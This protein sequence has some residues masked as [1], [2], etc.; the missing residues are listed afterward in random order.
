[1]LFFS[2]IRNHPLIGLANIAR[3]KQPCKAKNYPFIFLPARLLVDGKPVAGAMRDFGV[4]R[5]WG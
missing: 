4:L 2:V 1:V 3:A 5:S